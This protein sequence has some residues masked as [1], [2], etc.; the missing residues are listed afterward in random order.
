MPGLSLYSYEII[1]Y[2]CNE[3]YVRI[4]YIFP[5]EIQKSKE[6]RVLIILPHLTY[7]A[8]PPN[9]LAAPWKSAVSC[10]L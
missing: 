6:R 1:K 4:A 2:L 8:H 7:T 10:L 9:A 5:E 3:R